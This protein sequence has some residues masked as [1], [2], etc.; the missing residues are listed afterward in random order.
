MFSH[1]IDVLQPDGTTKKK[2]FYRSFTCDDPSQKGKRKCESM[3]AEWSMSEEREYLN[4]RDETRLTVKRALDR[5]IQIKENVLS[6][7]TVKGYRQ[8][9]GRYFDD[10]AT[11][12]LCDLTNAA[13]QEFV[14]N[15]T[16][17][18]SAKSVKNIYGLL[19]ATL[20]T[21]VPDIRLH[22]K[23]PQG[24]IYAANVPTDEDIAMLIDYARSKN[25][26]ILIAIYLAAFGTLRRSEICALSAEDINRKTNVIHVHRVVVVDSDNKD[27]IKE[28]PK[29]SS[30]DRYIELP[31]FVIKELP[32]KGRVISMGPDVLTQSF[33]RVVRQYGGTIFRFHDLRHYAAS[34]MH[35]IGVPDQYIMERGGWSSDRVLKR[36]YRGSIDSY[37]HKFTVLTNEH[38]AAIM[39]RMQ[40]DMQHENGESEENQCL[41]G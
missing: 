25:P 1:S 40:H 37:A 22:V 29:N 8:I 14:N 5:Y 28:V 18:R 39:Q 21:F 12:R 23:L 17:G 16:P 33:R 10:I 26:D 36:V 2:R 19:A 7:S 4:C 15:I 9:A 38:S 6:P 20:Y 24:R 34:I 3:A 35:A 31:E 11:V 32:K 41:S 13:I 27:V 30:S